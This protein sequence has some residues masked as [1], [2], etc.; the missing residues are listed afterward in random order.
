MMPSAQARPRIM[1]GP[2]CATGKASPDRNLHGMSRVRPGPLP[3]P[4][5]GPTSLPETAY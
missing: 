3:Q 1:P 2:V 4:P 5:S